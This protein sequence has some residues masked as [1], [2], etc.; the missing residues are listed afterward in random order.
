M[1]FLPLDDVK[2]SGEKAFEAESLVEEA[3]SDEKASEAEEAFSDEN[4][5][6]AES[7]VCENASEAES[8]VEEALSDEPR[9]RSSFL[10]IGCAQTLSL[11][12]FIIDWK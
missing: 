5:S 8:L 2:F 4:A 9:R 7:L 10:A 12:R 3:L 11:Y 1:H 6:E